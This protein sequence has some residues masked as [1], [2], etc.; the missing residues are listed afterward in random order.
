M[1][2]LLCAGSITPA[3]S[4]G[5]FTVLHSFSGL[6]IEGQAPHCTLVEVSP[7]VFY[8]TTSVGPSRSSGG[9][10][11]SITSGGVITTLHDFSPSTEGNNPEG[12]MVQ[13]QD[14]N[15]YGVNTLGGSGGQGTIFRSDLNGN[16][17]IL[18][19][20]S[21]G[22]GS[23]PFP[24]FPALNGNFFGTNEG[25]A[26]AGM[27]FR[28]TMAGVMNNLYNFTNAQGTP[29]SPVLQASDGNFY[30]TTTGGTKDYIYRI[31]KAG[32]ITLLASF[33]SGAL[34]AN[35]LIQA[36]NGTLYGV[37]QIGNTP[38]GF[39]TVF[40][41]TM[42]G[43]LTTLHTFGN[44]LDGGVPQTGLMQASDGNIY[45][46]TS[47]GGS[48][49]GGTI[50]RINPSTNSFTTLFSF[51]LADGIDPEATSAGLL[52]GSDGKL[53]GVTVSGG[54]S[55]GGTVYSY[56]LGLPKPLPNLIR[57]SPA[58]GAVGATVLLTGLNLLGAASVTFNG[59]AATFTQQGA[60]YIS[61]A[62]PAGATTGPI[63]VTTPNGT[64]TSRSN[65][66][67]Q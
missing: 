29:S 50:F 49:G 65:F 23:Q 35:G 52:Q 42:A 56:D 25:G 8:G 21:G 39:G 27:F 14:G 11:F 1:V 31:T 30:G 54:A 19:S 22:N 24:L 43:V 33:N 7:G 26:K 66:T 64:V 9:T 28:M 38:S 57:F 61:T 6:G 63:T 5:T 3:L 53:Y 12:R 37:T 58:S 45:G 4:Q 62:V 16:T 34:P 15:L 10:I 67:V 32:V 13:A 59:T 44:G 51:I 20:F 47:Q 36:S 48:A 18:Q 40:S 46:T 55:N 17:T 41:V 60:N 2:L